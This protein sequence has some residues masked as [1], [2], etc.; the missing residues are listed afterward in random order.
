[1]EDII[2][3]RLISILL[4]VTL[5]AFS[6]INVLAAV[7]EPVDPNIGGSGIEH[8][9]EIISRD[10]KQSNIFLAWHPDFSGYQKAAEYSFYSGGA[11]ISVSIGGSYY[12][13]SIGVAVNSSHPSSYTIYADQTRY[14]RPGINGNKYEIVYRYGM[15]NYNANQ[16]VSSQIG[17]R[18]DYE[19]TEIVVYYK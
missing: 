19:A 3:K 2:M 15:Y 4:V 9:E 14:S 11:P 10:L 1:M 12:W 5:L 8:R 13:L 7:K 16:W 18:Y 17:S 6:S